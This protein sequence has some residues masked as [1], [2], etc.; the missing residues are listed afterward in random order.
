MVNFYLDTATYLHGASSLIHKDVMAPHFLHW[1]IM[2][3]AKKLGM[4]SYDLWGIDEDRWPGVTRFKMG[5]GGRV[6]EYPRSM[7]I[8]FRPM[9]YKTYKTL[10]KVL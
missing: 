6:D 9:W 4:R 3:D 5:F 8:I 1:R 2:Q 7:D 10:R